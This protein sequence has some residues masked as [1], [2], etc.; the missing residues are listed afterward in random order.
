MGAY[1]IVIYHG[2]RLDRFSM[3]R[4]QAAEKRL[5]YELTII[6]GSYNSGVSAS[7]GTHDGG[8]AVDLSA[9]D[10][11]RKCRI[12]RQEGWAAWHRPTIPRL[13]NE[14]IHGIQ[15]DNK[16]LS[17]GAQSQVTQYYR[18]YNGLASWGK[19]YQWRPNP[20]PHFKFRAKPPR[21]KINIT[22]LQKAW[23]RKH[24]KTYGKGKF[25]IRKFAK[26]LQKRGW[27]KNW[28]WRDATYGR[29]MQVAV[30]TANKHYGIDKWT[31]KN[32]DRVTWE[33]CK[34]LGFAPYRVKVEKRPRKKIVRPF[35][36][37]VTKTAK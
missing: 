6:Q 15:Y 33:L 2:K 34:K 12:L 23:S 32:N 30:R 13:W 18:G 7:A 35:K 37:S 27:L 22:V 28:H 10:W 16:R 31:G 14:H 9:W 3:Q 24:G 1:D 4:I 21:P 8:G 11:E 17:S 25:I 19:D 29:N 36:K 20:I 5:G 26:P